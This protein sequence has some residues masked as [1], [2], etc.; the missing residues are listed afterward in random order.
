MSRAR[1][2][3]TYTAVMT[4]VAGTLAVIGIAW[5]VATFAITLRRDVDDL[6]QRDQYIHGTYK[7]PQKG[8]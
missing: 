7:V 5:Q 3:S 8:Q 4:A 1:P 6:Q 2:L